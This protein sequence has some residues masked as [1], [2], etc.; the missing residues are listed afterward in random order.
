MSTTTTKP[1]PSTRSSTGPID[2]VGSDLSQVLRALKLSG[3]KDTLPERLALA[4]QRQLGH[5]AFLQLLLSDEVA[6]R[7]SRSALLRVA[8]AGLDPAMRNQTCDEHPDLTY[9]RNPGPT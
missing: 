9:D 4:R 6:R 5:A 2:P 1:A 8:K 7:E 3:L